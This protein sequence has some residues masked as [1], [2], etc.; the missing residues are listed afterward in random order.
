MEN[1]FEY[2][3][4]N[5][6][7]IRSRTG[8]QWLKLILSLCYA[9][10]LLFLLAMQSNSSRYIIRAP[11]TEI[12]G[13][14]GR[15]IEFRTQNGQ[16]VDGIPPQQWEIPHLVL[17]R[18]AQ[19]ANPS[20]RSI[21]ISV[22]GIQ[23]P[24]SGA[25]V[26]LKILTQHLTHQTS[27][28]NQEHILIWEETRYIPG[29]TNNQSI[30]FEKVITDQTTGKFGQFNTPADYYQVDI[31]IT[32]LNNPEE[33]PIYHFHQD[34][35][36][37]LENQWIIN[38]PEVYE[39]SRSPAPSKL[40]IYYCDP[41]PQVNEVGDIGS[42]IE[43][44]STTDFII[45][46]L[47]PE[48]Q[49]AITKT[50][51][52]WKFPWY[53][54]WRSYRPEEPPDTLSIAL[55]TGSTWFHGTSEA[56]GSAGISLRVDSKD[57]K[58]YD[59]LSDSL[60]ATFYHELFH[61]IQRGINLH[62]GGDGDI[63]GLQDAWQFFSEGTAVLA[64]SVGQPEVQFST[65]PGLP[66]Y[67]LEANG[68]LAG[69]GYLKRDLERSYHDI[70]PYHAA[71]YWRFLYE[72]CGGMVQG[73]EN[74]VQGMQI[75]RNALNVLYSR[76]IVDI[77][78]SADIVSHLPAIMDEA[79]QNTPSC[80]FQNYKDSLLGFSAAVYQLHLENGRCL[81]PGSPDGCGFYDPVQRYLHLPIP[82]YEYSG[83]KLIL[84]N[85]NCPD[86]GKINNSFGMQFV[87]IDLAPDTPENDL[88]IKLLQSAQSDAEIE[89]QVF[90][91]HTRQGKDILIQK[92]PSLS[93]D[94][95]NEKNG[96]DR[97][98]ALSLP[99]DELEDVNKL[100]IVITRLDNKENQVY[101]G[102]YSIMV[103]Q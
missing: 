51:D 91:I 1:T 13:A 34:Y 96:I 103:F 46:D 82:S 53:A 12:T 102:D 90:I 93:T 57:N 5:Q 11:H 77:Q 89:L 8:Q 41:L 76:K 49:A 83:G 2:S 6:Q 97:Q 33:D 10:I 20:E 3:P 25:I 99:L 28:G 88:N 98:P 94:G 22:K 72:K 70:D 48:I 27:K 65:S 9:I 74:P 71:L 68:Y 26:S 29:T 81:Q 36:F 92:L 79:I 17:M 69:G 50:S 30:Q 101:P 32:N 63:D 43:Q 62:L 95:E 59:N 19:L 80:P 66:V 55:T 14:S 31:R 40:I 85:S 87:E 21:E 42:S 23:I 7:L 58:N 56:R 84:E 78:A 61:N 60:S 73:K 54:K 86:I 45:S 52:G 24:Q 15:R 39:D 100:G 4:L 38:L 67:F 47:V 18:N 44:K 75:I 37:L 64:T 16:Q 35:A